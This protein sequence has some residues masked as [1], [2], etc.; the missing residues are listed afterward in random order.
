MTNPSF[1]QLLDSVETLRPHELAMLQERIDHSRR[2]LTPATQQPHPVDAFELFAI[3]FEE[4]A[5]M[6]AKDRDALVLRA[7]KSLD[8]WIDQELRKHRARWML[9]VGG[10]ITRSSSN[11]LEYPSYED[12]EEIGQERGLIPFVFVQTPMIETPAVD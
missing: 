5:A 3:P 1:A 4:Y 12:L 6:G 7:Y 8:R 9:V 10:E 11:L 2:R